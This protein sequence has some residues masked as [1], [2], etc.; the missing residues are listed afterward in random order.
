MAGLMK[1]VTHLLLPFMRYWLPDVAVRRRKFL[2]CFKVQHPRNSHPVPSFSLP[3]EFPGGSFAI[4]WLF[5][6]RLLHY[7]RILASIASPPRSFPSWPPT[8]WRLDLLFFSILIYSISEHYIFFLEKNRSAASEATCSILIWNLLYYA[9][10]FIL[11]MA[12][13]ANFVTFFTRH[14]LSW[15]NALLT[16]VMPPR[17]VKKLP[18]LLFHTVPLF[19]YL[20]RIVQSKY[21]AYRPIFSKSEVVCTL[22]WLTAAILIRF[23]VAFTKKGLGWWFGM[24]CT[25]HFRNGQAWP[26]VS[27]T[28]WSVDT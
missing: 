20:N 3:F 10:L 17:I 26:N 14:M 25:A 18:V 15:M 6:G 2:F 19:L 7:C 27:W 28:D 5:R 12:C 8:M 1:P 21:W 23:G 11:E 24:L 13:A 22:R 9:A 16:F 4:T